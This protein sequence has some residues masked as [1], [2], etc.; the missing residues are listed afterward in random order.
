MILYTDYLAGE[1]IEPNDSRTVMLNVSK[2]LTTTDEISLDNETEIVELD[3][4]GGSTPQSVP[5][6]YVP[7]EGAQE[8][9]DS[10][11]ETTIVTPATGEDQ[12]YIIPI[13]VGTTALIILGAGIVI[14]KK[15]I[16]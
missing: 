9:D 13:I 4:P 8:A 11:A 1:N 7:G 6:N 15:K 12:N 2:K 16:L 10:M 5:G 3:R 14:I